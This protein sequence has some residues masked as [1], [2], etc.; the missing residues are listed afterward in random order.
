MIDLEKTTCLKLSYNVKIKKLVSSNLIIPKAEVRRL[1]DM[2]YVLRD[3]SLAKGSKLMYYMYRG[4]H[5]PKHKKLFK[6]YNLRWDIT[7]MPPGKIKNEF[8][9]TVGHH[10]KG[11]EIYEVLYGEALY[12]FENEKEFLVIH[13]RAGARVYV[14]YEYWHV[15]INHTNK[16]LIMANLMPEDIKSNY[17]DVQRKHGMAYY[18]V[19]GNRFIANKNFKKL[20]K[21]KRMKAK[22]FRVPIYWEFVN[23]PERFK[24][25]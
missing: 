22:K 2:K 5:L 19:K 4:V 1:K 9:K 8:V 11:V 21:I 17:K 14:P 7:I 3:P 15:T 13:A 18:Y 16:L 23:N 20:P 25:K 24:L 10:H 12:V 6:K